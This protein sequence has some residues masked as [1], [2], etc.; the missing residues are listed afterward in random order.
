MDS[1]NRF[2]LKIKRKQSPFYSFLY[3][4]GWMYYGFN[5]PYI[6]LIHLPL[7]YIDSV[8]KSVLERMMDVFWRGPLFKARC[9]QVGKNL[10]L[11]NEIPL[12]NGS[13]L[14]I[15]VGNNVTIGRV[16]FSSSKIF[17]EAVL[18]IG[19]NTSINYGTNI[20][21]TKEVIIGD[22]CMISGWCLIMDSDDHPISPLKRLKKLSVEKE[23]VSPVIIGNN[24]WIGA[25]SAVLKGV[26]IGNNSIIGTHSVVTE[27]V[28]PNCLYAGVPAKLVKKDI[29]KIIE[30]KKGLEFLKKS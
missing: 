28:P 9:E 5:M 8:A 19:S 14:K 13:N 11:P 16:T 18:R 1:L 29:D 3:R 24:V 23:E 20:S 22:N 25:Y 7:Y 15:Y 2:I 4:L 27:D 21:I 26:T 12:I 17:D 6:K 10:R 30:I